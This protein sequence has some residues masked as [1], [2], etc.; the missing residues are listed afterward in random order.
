M[1]IALQAMARF[2]ISPDLVASS[3]L[4]P[5]CD[6]VYATYHYLEIKLKK[7]GSRRKVIPRSQSD[8]SMRQSYPEA[9]FAPVTI[10]T[11]TNLADPSSGMT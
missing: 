11:P 2:G 8:S 5:T 9:S 7:L 3:L 6:E 4:S 10:A 1:I